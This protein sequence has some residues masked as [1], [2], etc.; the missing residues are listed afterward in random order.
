MD[1]LGCGVVDGV[2]DGR[3]DSDGWAETDGAAVVFRC[4]PV[5]FDGINDG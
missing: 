5:S 1:A 2:D 3:I 4:S